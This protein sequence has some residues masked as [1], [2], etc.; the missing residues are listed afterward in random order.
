MST[1]R[2]RHILIILLLLVMPAV[3]AMAGEVKAT[4][5]YNLSN[6]TGVLPYN[7]PKIFL[8]ER[9]S[10]IYVMSGEAVTIFNN[11]GMEVHQVGYDPEIGN[12]YDVAVLPDGDVLLLAN[13]ARQM[14]VM[15]CNYRLE[16]QSVIE[17]KNLPEEYVGFS[18]NRILYRDGLLY[19]VGSGAMS[20]VVT[21]TEGSFVKAYEIAT[22]LGYGEQE[23]NDTGM[24]GFTLD[25]EGNM[26]ITLPVDGL[27]ARI[28][29]DGTV[30]VFGKRGSGPGKF[31]VPAG[32]TADRM[33][34]YLVSD[35]LR[36][37]V[38]VFD[39][40][41]RFVREFGYRGLRPG[42]L[43]VPNDIAVD[44]AN[45]VYV[46]QL[47]RRGVSVYQLIYN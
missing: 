42:N 1:G 6:F 13:N 2:Y 30:M 44:D 29:A 11:T 41:F 21:D 7:W 20:V 28:T 32:I 25:R 33:G 14:R 36:N 17:L 8:D 4:Y 22:L 43:I 9:N 10:E 45:K 39:K 38:L 24:D 35:R 40:D 37:V 34:N 12:I 15:R 23:R 47:R 18:P 27:A 46:A 3:P 16:P 19:L 31:G 26:L 5:L